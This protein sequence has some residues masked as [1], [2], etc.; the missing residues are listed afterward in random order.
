MHFYALINEA[1]ELLE[2]VELSKPLRVDQ[3]D[4]QMA[5]VEKLFGY[6]QGSF[7]RGV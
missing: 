5:R 2:D 3:M 1:S 4:K 6:E 7:A